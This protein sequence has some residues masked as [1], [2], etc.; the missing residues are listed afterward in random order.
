MSEQLTGVD[1]GKYDQSEAITDWLLKENQQY[2]MLEGRNLDGKLTF[3]AILEKNP[4]S[5]ETK[6][7]LAGE[8]NCSFTINLISMEVRQSTC[9][10]EAIAALE[11]PTVQL[12]GT[13]DPLLADD[14]SDRLL[15]RIACVGAGIGASVLFN[16]LAICFGCSAC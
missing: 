12:L 5:E 10:A 6:I 7:E 2:S 3:A 9:S 4:E 13:F 8:Q 14:K 16:R 1:L 11:I 15:T